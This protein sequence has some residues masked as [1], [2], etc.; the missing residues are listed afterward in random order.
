MAQWLMASARWLIA[1][2]LAESQHSDDFDVAD[3]A[4]FSTTTDLDQHLAGGAMLDIR[5]VHAEPHH[6]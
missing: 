3:S 2:Q 1:N 5:A 4:T 6:F